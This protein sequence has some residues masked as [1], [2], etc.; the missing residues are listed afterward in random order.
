MPRLMLFTRPA[1]ARVVELSAAEWAI[2][3]ARRKEVTSVIDF[4]GLALSCAHGP[5]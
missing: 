5:S 4:L 1:S 3:V 2:H